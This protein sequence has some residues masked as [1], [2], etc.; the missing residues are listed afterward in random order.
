[1]S[2]MYAT[3]SCFGGFT[4]WVA[5]NSLAFSSFQSTTSTTTIARAPLRRQ[6]WTMFMPMPP[7]PQTAHT[8]P[9]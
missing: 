3:A 1:M 6:P 9:G 5:P 8:A 7:T 4:V 2:L